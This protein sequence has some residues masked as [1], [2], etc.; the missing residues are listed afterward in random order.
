[1]PSLPF[2][3]VLVVTLLALILSVGGLAQVDLTPVHPESSVTKALKDFRAPVYFEANQGQAPAEYRYVMRGDG[4]SVGFTTEGLTVAVAGAEG[5]PAAAG[6]RFRWEGSRANAEISAEDPARVRTS[7]LNFG[8]GGAADIG[9]VATYQRVRYRGVYH[10]TD[11]VYYWNG[12]H[13]EFDIEVG[14]DAARFSPVLQIAGAESLELE[15]DGSLVMQHAGR[16]IVQHAPRA[17]VMTNGAEAPIS[18]RYRLL[19]GGRVEVE[20]DRQHAG[21]PV[22]IDPILEFAG[23]FGGADE[24]MDVSVEKDAQGNVYLLGMARSTPL[25]GEDDRPRP[26]NA[27]TSTYFISKVAAD[28]SAVYFTT[29]IA[30]PSQSQSTPTRLSVAPDGN[31]YLTY[32]SRGYLNTLNPTVGPYVYPNNNYASADRAVILAINAAGDTLRYRTVMGC[33]QAFYAR[34]QASNEGLTVATSAACTG[35]PTSAGAYTNSPSTT[36][37]RSQLFVAHLNLAGT[38][39]EFSTR[40][41]GNGDQGLASF[42]R[43]KDGKIWLSGATQ[44]MD[45]PTTPGAYSAKTT[46]GTDAFVLRLS[47]DASRLEASTILRGS[48]TEQAGNLVFGEDG[49]VYVSVSYP[50]SDF[51]VSPNAYQSAFTTASSA[52]VSLNAQL[53]TL[54]WSTFYPQNSGPYGLAVGPSGRVAII[55]A[56]ISGPLPLSQNALLRSNAEWQSRHVGILS[57]DASQLLF[58]SYFYSSRTSSGSRILGFDEASI[59]LVGA[60][61]DEAGAPPSTGPSITIGQGDRPYGVYFA[62]IRLDNSTACSV[63]LN[64]STIEVGPDDTEATLDVTAQPGCPWLVRQYSYVSSPVQMEGNAGIGNGRV[65]LRF[66]RNEYST[67]TREHTVFADVA[68]AKVVQAMAPCTRQSITPGSVRF[69]ADGGLVGA[70]FDIP[71]ECRWFYRRPDPWV[72]VQTAQNTAMP[73]SGASKTG[74]RIQVPSNAFAAR[75]TSLVIGN[76]TVPIYQEGGSCMATV[77]PQVVD[78]PAAGGSARITFATSE[79]SCEWM[80]APSSRLQVAGSLGGRGSHTFDISLSP[81]PTNVAQV[82]TLYVGG[83]TVQVRQAA[84]VCEAVVSPL[85]TQMGPQ[86]SSLNVNVTASGPSCAWRPVISEPWITSHVGLDDMKGTGSTYLTVHANDT[87][88]T[89][90]ATIQILGKTME[91]VQ[92]GVPT[93]MLNI[94]RSDSRGSATITLNGRTLYGS[95]S[96]AMPIGSTFTVSAPPEEVPEDGV[97]IRNLGWDNSGELTRSY[98]MSENQMNVVLNSSSYHRL[99]TEVV[100]NA[101]ND[102]SSVVVVHAHTPAE[103]DILE[104]PDGRYYRYGVYF[105]INAIDGSQSIFDRWQ[106]DLAT[107][108]QTRSVYTMIGRPLTASARFRATA[109]VTSLSF[110]P[111]RLQLRFGTE[112]DLVN[113]VVIIR[114]NY[115]T[116]VGIAS[117]GCSTINAPFSSSLN[118]AKTP[119][120]ANVSLELVSAAVASPGQHDCFV[121]FNIRNQPEAV[122]TVPVDLTIGAPTD[123]EGDVR[124]SAVVEAAAYR[125]LPL[126]EGSI[127][128]IFGRNMA[129]STTTAS[130]LPLPTRLADV[131]VQLE[132]VSSGVVS[133]APLFFVSP[134]QINFLVPRGHPQGVSVLRVRRDGFPQ[135]SAMVG[136]STLLPS[137]FTANSDGAGVPA[138][139]FLRVNKATGE[140]SL[141]ALS[142]CSDG[143]TYCLPRRLHFDPNAEEG[144]LILYGTGFPA[145]GYTPVAQLNGENVDV[146]YMGPQGAFEGLDQVNIRVPASVVGRDAVYIEFSI[147]GFTANVV[148]VRF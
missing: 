58:G 143:E 5:P 101:P 87:G 47:A 44:S 45:F 124:V 49:S 48:G 59:T 39:M 95:I 88:V 127:A 51:P 70:F 132:H 82:E 136:I 53:S 105:R 148:Q 65:K 15:S 94:S 57:A 42:V 102:G 98:R 22:R 131:N 125:R 34:L 115:E 107:Y 106:G 117:Y 1:M 9:R 120:L 97:L 50:G 116:E 32:S 138:G 77:S 83:R 8:E 91:V 108:G 3:R 12:E 55:S 92:Y 111:S 30:T 52:I 4:Y 140:Q 40:F 36:A 27:G 113:A 62:R 64:P 141:E 23:Y 129:G 35:L 31:M 84:G 7:Y 104:R 11:V 133:N 134:T 79:E 16:R 109:G 119:L 85:Y 17:F 126:P 110:E 93:Q 142:A 68:T 90:T 130:T 114:A 121:K 54:R 28:L 56:L 145:S 72:N 21:A 75:E 80:A 73:T 147:N 14:A 146:T 128:T 144:Y 69:G 43:D 29:Y 123:F 81:N 122:I 19:G 118:T 37:W 99:R 112:Q 33:E 13:L 67:S 10:D 18:S 24:N 89:R 137:F 86:A 2:R 60:A 103:G 76:V 96:V 41:G 6:L 139:Q 66:P 46:T 61:F 26:I 38:A 71:N 63:Q 100:D 135:P 25:P 74:V 20:F 78:L